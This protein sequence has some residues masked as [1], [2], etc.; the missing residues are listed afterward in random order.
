MS[1]TQS[2]NSEYVPLRCNEVMET[3]V[4]TVHFHETTL[5][6]H[7]TAWI[8]HLRSHRR[9]LIFFV[10]VSTAAIIL[11]A[12]ALSFALSVYLNRAQTAVTIETTDTQNAAHENINPLT[13]KGKDHAVY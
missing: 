8:S 5:K 12:A 7:N 9:M 1:S 11:S 3:L 4:H 6:E 2:P 13:Q 10:V